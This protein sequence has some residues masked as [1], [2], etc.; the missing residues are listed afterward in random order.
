MPFKAV[1]KITIDVSTLEID[2]LSIS[3]H[4]LNGPKGVGAL[5]VRKGIQLDPLILGGGQ[6][7][8]LRSGTENVASIVGFGKGM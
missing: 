7:G 1:G 6:E 2:L 3:S 8:G 5:Y 4:K